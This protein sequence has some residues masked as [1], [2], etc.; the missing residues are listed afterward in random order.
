M[1]LVDGEE[2]DS[3]VL[4][5]LEKALV[6]EPLRRDVQELQAAGGEAIRDVAHL[7]G[8]DARIES[9]GIDSL[10]HERVDLILHQ[11]DQRRDD[12]GD[13][14]EQKRRQLVTEALAGSRREHRERGAA[15]EQRSDHF[16]LTRPVVGEA[17]PGGEH[18]ARVLRFHI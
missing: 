17:E 11:G 15:G 14:V 4:Q 6:V 13:A 10:A 18:R 9:G 5:L 16:L 3:R 2:R 1:R 12:H 7:V 8:A